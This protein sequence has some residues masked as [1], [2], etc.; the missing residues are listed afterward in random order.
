[1]PLALTRVAATGALQVTSGGFRAGA[2][3]PAKYSEYADGVSPPL[4]W[5]AVP[6]AKSY[7]VI[8]EDPDA[9][10]KPFVHWLAWNIPANVT[11]LPEGVQEQPRLTEPDGVLQ[12]RNTRG[13]SGY[14]GPRPP[15][16]DAAHHYHFQVFALDTV[17]ALPFG[18]DRDEL[19]KALEGHVLGK[20]E[21][22]GR[23]AQPQQPPK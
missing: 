15:V 17:L 12:G 19:V 20:G 13:S 18:A 7:A 6:G 1:V 16:G 8:M 14:Y 10:Q 11:S 21:V 2:A 23:Y 22:I 5:S 9:P 3:M 4:A